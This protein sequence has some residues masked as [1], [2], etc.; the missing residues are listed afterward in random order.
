MYHNISVSNALKRTN[1][2]HAQRVDMREKWRKMGSPQLSIQKN[3]VYNFFKNLYYGSDLLYKYTLGMS[4]FSSHKIKTELGEFPNTHC[5]FQAYRCPDNKLYVEYLQQGK[6]QP[7]LI[8]EQ[9]K[10]WD[11][12]KVQYMENILRIK[13]KTYPD[14]KNILLDTG[15][16]L[17]VRSSKDNFWGTGI[18]NQGKNVHGLILTNLRNE[19]L[20]EEFNKG[21]DESE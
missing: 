16:R 3:F 4:N 8:D 10:D 17:L 9:V 19:W 21:I 5:A 11:E 18:N 12:K 20:L 6:F 14:I 7:N 1:Y 13:Y 15:L 2:Y